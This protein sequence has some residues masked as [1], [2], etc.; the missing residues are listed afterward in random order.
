MVTSTRLNFPISFPSSFTEYST[1]SWVFALTAIS[2]F[3]AT[4]AVAI[5]FFALLSMNSTFL[6]FAPFNADGRSDTVAV[7]ANGPVGVN[8]TLAPL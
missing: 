1:P 7:T 2:P 4:V 5:V 6:P 8:C 3:D